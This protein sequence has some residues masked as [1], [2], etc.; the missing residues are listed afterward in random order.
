MTGRGL[1]FG[2]LCLQ[3][4]PVPQLADRWRLAEQLGFDLLYVADHTGDYRGL[5]GYWLDGWTVLTAMAAETT[6]I[7]IGTLVSNPILRHPVMLAKTAVAIDHLSSGRLELGIGTGIAGFDHAAVGV[8]YWSPKERVSRF[9]EYIQVVD[10]VLRSSGTYEFRG[11][12]F[13]TNGTAMTPAPVQRPP[14]ADHH[15]RPVADRAARGR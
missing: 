8:P 9:R 4:A 13:N 3:D 11:R 12:W 10:E 1:R 6:S 5:R 2:I 14:S 15:C 7:R